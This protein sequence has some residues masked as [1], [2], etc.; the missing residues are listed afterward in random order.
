MGMSQ[1]KHFKFS[2]TIQT[3]N[4]PIIAS[5]RGLAWFCQ[6]EINRQIAVAGSKEEDWK[7]DNH[8]VTFYFSSKANRDNFATV[9][10]N[11]F[12]PPWSIKELSDNNPPE[13]QN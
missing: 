7:R 13:P 6:N 12:R 9:A 11:L 5:M 3:D 2:I 1:H 10:N 4:F 8:C